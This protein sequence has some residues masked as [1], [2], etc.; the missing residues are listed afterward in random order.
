VVPWNEYLADNVFGVDRLNCKVC[1]VEGEEGRSCEESKKEMVSCARGQSKAAKG[2]WVVVRGSSGLKDHSALN[3]CGIQVQHSMAYPFPPDMSGKNPLKRIRDSISPYREAKRKIFSY[4]L[5]P[6]RTCSP[7]NSLFSGPSGEELEGDSALSITST[8]SETE[9]YCRSPG[10]QP[11]QSS[12]AGSLFSDGEEEEG[13]IWRPQAQ[14]KK[15]Y[16]FDGISVPRLGNVIRGLF[17]VN[18]AYM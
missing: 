18:C 14:I 1:F 7:A 17:S 9:F 11:S 6:E 5:S 10:E 16:V 4:S 3:W 13:S 8:S 12:L 15:R 2:A